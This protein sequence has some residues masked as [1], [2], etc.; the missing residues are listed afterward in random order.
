M[1]AVF[2][3]RPEAIKLA[4]V[5]AALTADARLQCLPVVSGQQAD[6]LPDFLATF[7]IEPARRLDVMRQDSDPHALLA[8]CVSALAPVLA[9]LRARAVIV[10]GDTTTALAGAIAAATADIPVI[11]VEAGLRSHDLHS[12]WPE[13][14][15]RLLVTQAASLHLAP[16]AGN[17]ANLRAEGVP[18]AA[19]RITGNPVIDAVTTALPRALPSADLARLLEASA[20][21]RRV[22]LTCHRRENF[23]ARL[24]A[25]L[26]AI[27]AFLAA[28][29]LAEL[30]CPVH[31]NPAVAPALHRH[32][33]Q[34][35]RAHL[36]PPL[37][38]HDFLALLNTADLVLSDSGGVQE[39]VTVTGTPLCILREVT[40][41]PEVLQGGLARLV[42][43]G[44]QLAAHLSAI[45]RSGE[46][47][48]RVRLPHN[49]FGDGH[50]GPRIA[51]A[52][53]DFLG[54]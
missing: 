18:A 4:P 23:G 27:A 35:P 45:A 15:N 32:L 10:Q 16:T 12:P 49:P 29:P 43:D 1:L 46:W 34:Q 20:G 17:A 50:S 9:D 33:G 19:I 54:A 8:R 7:G 53:A 30:Y 21:R 47:P 13:E 14:A 28:C 5:I 44:A 31:P 25:Y 3:T 6:L 42:V 2:G 40:E 26:A 36:L 22:L 38:Y 48:V 52:I 11:H 37:G 51:R 39:E 41:R 24:E